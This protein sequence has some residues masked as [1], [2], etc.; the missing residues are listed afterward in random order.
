MRFS[1][2][3]V[4]AVLALALLTAGCQDSA[5]DSSETATAP[6]TSATD[7]S[8]KKPPLT[9]KDSE[10]VAAKPSKSNSPKAEPANGAEARQKKPPQAKPFEPPFA[11]RVDLFAPPSRAGKKVAKTDERSETVELQGFVNV[12]GIRAV[13]AINDVIAPIAQGEERFGI[14]VIAIQPPKVVLQRGRQR[15]TTTLEN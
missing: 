15:W 12:D 11:D 7:V 10:K 2:G 3:T 5:P 4:P 8:T 14:Q 1:H 13:L 6:A 9:N